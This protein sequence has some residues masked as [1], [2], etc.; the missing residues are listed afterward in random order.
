[1]VVLIK[2]SIYVLCTISICP[3]SNRQVSHVVSFLIYVQSELKSIDLIFSVPQAE[4]SGSKQRGKD[5]I[6]EE[7]SGEEWRG[8]SG[9]G[10]KQSG[11]DLRGSERI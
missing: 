1:M 4:R 9:T 5:K 2:L 11:E 8:E 3:E 10:E 6:G 7:Q